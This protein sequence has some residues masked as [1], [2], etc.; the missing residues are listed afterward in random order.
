MEKNLYPNHPV[1][2]IK[3]GPSECGKSVFLTSL[4]LNIINEYD[5]IYIYSPSLHQDLYQ[6]LVKC[7]SNYIPIN[8]IPSILNEEDIDVVIKEIVN[9]KDF[10]KSDTEIE[11][12]ESIEELKYPRE[13]DDWGVIILDDLNEKEMNDPRVK[14]MFKRSR[15]NNLSIF[16]I[17]Q[18]YYDL[19]KRTIRAIG[20]IYH[21]FKPNNFLDV[22][23][24][25]QDKASMDMALD[26]F[27]YLFSTCWNKKKSTSHY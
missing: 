22:R 1:R 16:I 18:D 19:P 24:I 6:K 21:I 9:S 10:E 12:Y 25:C 4:I 8:I 11:T 3:T 27:N 14:A 17:S 2:C 20:N 7:F 15:H 5:K 23:N 26:E 13:Y